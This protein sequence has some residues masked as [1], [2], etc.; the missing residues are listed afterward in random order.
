MQNKSRSGIRTATLQP[1]FLKKNPFGAVYVPHVNT[2]HD[3]AAG[4]GGK[5]TEPLPCTVIPTFL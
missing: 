4:A 2:T 1:K 3:T 5:G